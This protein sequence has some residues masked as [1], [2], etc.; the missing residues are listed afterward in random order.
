MD[1][2]LRPGG[3]FLWV[4]ALPQIRRQRLYALLRNGQIL[5]WQVQTK[6]GGK[7]IHIPS[8]MVHDW[9]GIIFV[10]GVSL[11]RAQSLLQD[12]NQYPRIYRP[13]I[14]RATIFNHTDDTFKIDLQYYKGSPHSASFNVEFEAQYTRI[15]ATH[16]ISRS[17]S[18][19]IAELQHPEQPDSPEFPVGRGRGYLWHLNN[20]RRLEEKDGGVYIQVESI[21]LSRG[22]PAI[23]AW[24]VNPIIRRI[25]RQALA[26]LLSATRRALLNPPA[27]ALKP[28]SVHRR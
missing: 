22:V 25:S 14:R 17:V 16:A 12:Y 11:Q 10:P 5:I 27:L 28:S 18:T 15:D 24:F 21:A 2:N 20:Y 4:D 13:D 26:S 3:P 7:T 23:I 9:M 6:E 8:G 19:R 1:A